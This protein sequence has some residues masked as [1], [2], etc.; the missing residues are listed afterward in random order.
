MTTYKE[1]QKWIKNE[2]GFTVKTCWIA[3]VKE[4]CGIPIKPAHNRRGD[5]RLYPCPTDKEKAIKEALK[6]FNML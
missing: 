3:D 5:K 1:I 2:F 4:K 6:H